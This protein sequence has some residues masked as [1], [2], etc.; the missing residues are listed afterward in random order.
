MK[1]IVKIALIVLLFNPVQSW[2]FRDKP[3]NWLDIYRSIAQSWV[4]P[5]EPNGFR[6]LYWGESL[7]DVRKS[8]EVK[9]L[10][11][12]NTT[13][14]EAYIITLNK[15]ESTTF[16]QLPIY[17]DH[18]YALFWNDQLWNIQLFFLKEDSFS[19]LK[20]AMSQSYGIP[21]E[22][23]QHKCIWYGKN[24]I[25]L[26]EELRENQSR[27]SFGSTRIIFDDLLKEQASQGW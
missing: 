26:L 2:A 19:S 16:L 11:E 24:T 23:G 10:K 21:Q 25:I 8:R 3:N 15:N 27:I 7:E 20:K 14:E 13:L 5:N 4:F 12:R 18:L 22:E 1:W 6:N 17:H 9:H